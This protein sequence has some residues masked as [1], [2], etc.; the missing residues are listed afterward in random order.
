M[1]KDNRHYHKLVVK[2]NGLYEMLYL[3]DYELGL[4]KKRRMKDVE[5]YGQAELKS[6]LLPKKEQS[7]STDDY[8]AFM[9]IFILVCLVVLVIIISNS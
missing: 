2:N 7:N 6:M 4:S 9:Y 5:V 1:H 3:T 8:D